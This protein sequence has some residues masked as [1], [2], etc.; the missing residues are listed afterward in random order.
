MGK[1]DGMRA[2]GSNPTVIALES[3]QSALLLPHNFPHTKVLVNFSVSILN[4]HAESADCGI[5]PNQST[6]M[7]PKLTCGDARSTSLD[8]HDRRGNFWG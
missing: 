7:L 3:L 6:K 2:A 8:V 5:P 1:V 4:L